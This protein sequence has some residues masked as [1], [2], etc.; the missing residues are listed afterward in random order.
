MKPSSLIITAALPLL[1]AAQVLSAPKEK[2]AQQPLDVSKGT[3]RIIKTSVS[4]DYNLPWIMKD[5]ETSAGSGAIIK[6]GYILTNAHVVSDATYIQV[7]KESDP[8][9]YEASIVYIGHDCDLALLKA[10]DEKFYRNTV[11]LEFGGIPELQSRVTTFGYPMGGS[12]ISITE[13][14]TSRI[15]IG[16]YS[17]SG[18]VSF[19]MIQTDAAINPGN[20]G[21][22]VMQ[23]NRIVGVAFQASANSDNIGYMIPVPVIEHFLGDIRDGKYDGFP[24]LG[25]F[26]ETL[27]NISY[28]R[29]L[30]MNDGQSGVLVSIVIPGGGAEQKLEPGDVILAIDS[31]PIANDGTITFMQGRIFYS[32]I[33]DRKQIGEEVAINVL[34]DKKIV[35]VSYRLRSYPSRISWFNEFETLP[36]YCIFGG[37]VFQNLSKEYLMTWDKWWQT[38]DRRLLYYYSYH[39]SDNLYPARKE[40]VVLNRVLPDESNTYLSDVHDRVIDT[41]NG[42]KILSLADVV[43]AFNKPAG[44]FHVIHFDGSSFPLV[45]KASDIEEANA[46]IKEKYNIPSLMRLN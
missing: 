31:V 41:I 1:L 25:V 21:G 23:N 38:A 18:S 24:T 2:K 29:F 10:K 19:L 5:P 22:P 43:E 13:G 45:L 46:R 26:T 12:R 14:I 16:E 4:P 9:M 6:G 27:D 36:R 15:E 37:L 40:F 11:E 20:S 39:L 33:I 44:G 35:R 8:Q 3:I 32:Y 34:R 30:G 7:K 17:H 42:M 28:R